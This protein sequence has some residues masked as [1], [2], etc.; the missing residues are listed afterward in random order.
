MR[1]RF[2]MRTVLPSDSRGG[3]GRTRPIIRNTSSVRIGCCIN[4]DGVVW[5]LAPQRTPDN[6]PLTTNEC[7]LEGS[8]WFKGK[9][10]RVTN[11]GWLGSSWHA[12][13][14]PAQ[15]SDR[16]RRPPVADPSHPGYPHLNHADV[17]AW[18][19]V[20]RW[21]VT[22]C[23]WLGSSW[24]RQ[25]APGAGRGAGGVDLRS[26]TPATRAY[27]H[28]NQAKVS[29]LVQDLTKPGNTWRCHGASWSPA[30]RRS[31]PVSRL[32]A[33]LQQVVRIQR[34]GVTCI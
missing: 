27:P 16:G 11:C 26:P 9:R 34:A 10:W 32:K 21:R 7:S 19:K 5:P 2:A 30:F 6:G 15:A 17:R 18:F 3:S 8:G 31:S 23:G 1:R 22:N 28:L 24:Q 14:P 25:R 33:G 12:S 29:G 4:S 20:K 13:E